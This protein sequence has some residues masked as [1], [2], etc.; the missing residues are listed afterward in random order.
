MVGDKRLFTFALAKCSCDV[1]FIKGAMCSQVS[2]DEVPSSQLSKDGRPCFMSERNEARE[3]SVAHTG[4]GGREGT[5]S[6]L[7]LQ[8][9]LLSILSG[10]S[11]RT[12][13]GTE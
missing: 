11:V 10:H 13:A 1:F 12:V 3:E 8:C 5:Q 6:V 7:M 2:G 4:Q 9:V